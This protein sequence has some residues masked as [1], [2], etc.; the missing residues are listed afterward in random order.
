MESSEKMPGRMKSRLPP[1][2]PITTFSRASRNRMKVKLNQVNRS[3]AGLPSFLSPTYPDECLPITE[4]RVKRDLAAFRLALERRYGKKPVVWKRENQTRKSGQRTGEEAPHAHFLVFGVEPEAA[5]RVWFAETWVRII[6]CPE[7]ARAKCYS[8][9]VRP[10]TWSMPTSWGEVTAY[11][12]KY[13]SKP[14]EEEV[15][16]DGRVWGIWHKAELPVELVEEELPQ[17]SFHPVR[18]VLRRYVERK[19]GRRVRVRDR[20]SSLSAYV[21]EATGAALN[22]WSWDIGWSDRAA[23]H[24]ASDQRKRGEGT[25]GRLPYTRARGLGV[26]RPAPTHR[27]VWRRDEK[28]AELA[29]RDSCPALSPAC[30]AV[31]NRCVVHSGTCHHGTITTGERLWLMRKREWTQ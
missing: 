9:Q 1:R 15:T 2:G 26:P 14:G 3:K 24:H 27:F 18:R 29:V 13:V 23:E 11:V 21:S 17:D 19:I 16:T 4:E 25:Y 5:D 30:F 20:W 6:E 22:R 28:R 8:V 31:G 12:E 7:A 10:V